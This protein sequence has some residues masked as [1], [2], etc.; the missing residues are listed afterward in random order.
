MAAS[1]DEIKATMLLKKCY[2]CNL[3]NGS[4]TP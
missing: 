1:T 2:A 3:A 4:M